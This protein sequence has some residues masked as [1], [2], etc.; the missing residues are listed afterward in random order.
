MD[1]QIFDPTLLPASLRTQLP[2]NVRTWQELKRWSSNDATQAL[3]KHP[4]YCLLQAAQYRLI[5]SSQDVDFSAAISY[6]SSPAVTVGQTIG[7]KLPRQITS[8]KSTA[9]PYLAIDQK[10]FLKTFK[11]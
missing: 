3:F 11:G 10:A 2:D 9:I 8:I 1:S 4:D 7:F 6:A 5:L